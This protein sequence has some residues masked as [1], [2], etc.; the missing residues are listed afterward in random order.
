[1]I[2][3]RFR[4]SHLQAVESIENHLR[5]DEPG[6]LF[7]V[8]RNDVPGSDIGAG[9]CDANLIGALIIMPPLTFVDI[10]A[11]EFPVFSRIVNPLQETPALFCL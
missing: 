10:R 3:V 11:A 8:R 1:M 5:D 2:L 4:V 7:V 9:S 6:I